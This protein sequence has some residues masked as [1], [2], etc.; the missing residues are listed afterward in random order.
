MLQRYY[1]SSADEH[2]DTTTYYTNDAANSGVTS[3]G[4]SDS[5]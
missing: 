2:E 4:G 1:D 3:D 5:D